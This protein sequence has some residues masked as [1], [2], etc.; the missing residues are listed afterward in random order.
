MTPLRQMTGASDASNYGRTPVRTSRSAYTTPARQTGSVSRTDA[1]DYSG[2]QTPSRATAT[3]AGAAAGGL[4]A[5]PETPRTPTFSGAGAAGMLTPQSAIDIKKRSLAL[6]LLGS[7]NAMSPGLGRSPRLLRKQQQQQQ[8]QQLESDTSEGKVGLSWSQAGGAAVVM[9]RIISSGEDDSAASASAA[10]TSTAAGALANVVV[11]SNIAAK[12]GKKERE[13]KKKI[14]GSKKDNDNPKEESA[15]AKVAKVP[16]REA[17]DYFRIKKQQQEHAANQQQQQELVSNQRQQQERA[18][19]LASRKNFWYKAAAQAD[20]EAAE[21]ETEDAED[22][23]G[24]GGNDVRTGA[25][26]DASG[27]VPCT[28]GAQD[29]SNLASR[30]DFWYKA[31]AQA[32]YEAAEAEA[33]DVED[34]G[35][36][37]T[38]GGGNNPVQPYTRP[39][40][41]DLEDEMRTNIERLLTGYSKRNPAGAGDVDGDDTVASGSTAVAPRP[42]PAAS[43]PNIF[44]F[45]DD[46]SND[47]VDDV[48]GELPTIVSSLA[49]QGLRTPSSSTAP[50]PSRGT[51]RSI[52]RTAASQGDLGSVF[53]RLG[54]HRESYLEGVSCCS[55][56]VSRT[57]RTSRTSPLLLNALE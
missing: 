41:P 28:A 5:V 52:G 9:Q 42:P 48:L 19:N 4:A 16:P 37:A 22:G 40:T 31:A 54:A 25:G 57:S 36:A 7:P 34:D 17:I 56:T 26:T 1:A 20:Y 13:K 53:F 43:K 27:S 10:G 39:A 46:R 51:P 14:G 21:A 33:E 11:G 50:T 18:S 24:G 44:K 12:S 49:M 45:T 6:R 8:K 2:W 35:N 29:I 3:P 38:G 15:K 30:K 23:G 32:D 55:F 47:R